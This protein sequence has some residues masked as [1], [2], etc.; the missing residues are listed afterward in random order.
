MFDNKDSYTFKNYS[1]RKTYLKNERWLIR[2]IY[3][4][5]FMVY[6]LILFYYKF[7]PPESIILTIILYFSFRVLKKLFYENIFLSKKVYNTWGKGAGAEMVIGNQ[8]SALGPDYKI[9]SDFQTGKGNIDFIVIGP[10]GIFTI[11]VKA[12]HGNI[13]CE[14]NWIIVNSRRV[15]RDM[16]SQT[17]AE[18]NWLTNFLKSKG[19]NFPVTGILAFP[20]GKIDLNSIHGKIDG[21]WIGGPYFHR[22]AI[23][24]SQNNLSKEQV[25]LIIDTLNKFTTV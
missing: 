4:I 19:S 2:G 12:D 13:S 23:N 5:L 3:L 24:K 14:N 6:F 1:W 16:I 9:I 7:R 8:L 18:M 15:D 20:Y 10:K 25:N 21:I 22:Y 17:W 11:E